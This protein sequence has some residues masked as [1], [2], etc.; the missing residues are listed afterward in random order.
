MHVTP[1]SNGSV[2]AQGGILSTDVLEYGMKSPLTKIKNSE[3]EGVSKKCAPFKTRL[4]G[5]LIWTAS[6]QLQDFGLQGIRGVGLCGSWM[7]ALAGPLLG[8]LLQP[9][10][11]PP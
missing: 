11:A 3:Q 9:F 4:S 8:T 10:S 6:S 7:T 1:S 5:E 2:L